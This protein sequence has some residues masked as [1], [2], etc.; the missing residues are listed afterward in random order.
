MS[1][2]LGVGGVRVLGWVEEVIV[3]EVVEGEDGFCEKEKGARRT[4][5]ELPNQRLLF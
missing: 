5:H 2:K 4:L 1:Y 3:R